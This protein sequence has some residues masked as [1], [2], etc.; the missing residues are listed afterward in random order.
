M[1]RP[2]GDASAAKRRQHAALFAA[3]GDETR[4][5]LVS[6]LCSGETRSIAQLTDGSKLTRQAITKHLRVL[7]GAGVVH[8]TRAGRESRFG[9]DPAPLSE[10]REYLGRVSAQWDEVLARLKVLVET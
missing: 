3:L 5:A 9:L 8:S 4:L 1:S 10:L 6:A 7:E 2:S